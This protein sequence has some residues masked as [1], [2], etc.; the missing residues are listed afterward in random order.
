M[1][2]PEDPANL[3]ITA[4]YFP[5][6]APGRVLTYDRVQYAATGNAMTS[7]VTAVARSVAR[8]EA[9]RPSTTRAVTSGRMT[10]ALRST[11]TPKSLQVIGPSTAVM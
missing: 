11:R 9:P 10:L 2:P 3:H 8:I 7:S 6:L 1:Q 5:A 4:D